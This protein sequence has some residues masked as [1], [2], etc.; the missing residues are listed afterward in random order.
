MKGFPPHVK[1]V[2]LDTNI[3]LVPYQFG[4]DV[5]EEIKRILPGVKVYTIPQV[6]REVKKLAR[7]SLHERL[8]ARIAERLLERIKVLDVDPEIP[9]DRMLVHLA[10]E[11]YVIATNDRELRRR[12][13]EVGGYSIYLREKNHLELG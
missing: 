1:G 4:V 6:V 3:L 13:R 5:L 11:G 12:I 2:V 7:G 9:T 8:G 10:K